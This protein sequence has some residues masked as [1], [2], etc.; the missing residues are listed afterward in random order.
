MKF[1]YKPLFEDKM[2]W[3]SII[4]HLLFGIFILIAPNVRHVTGSFVIS[5]LFGDSD[6][7]FY[8]LTSLTSIAGL[9]IQTK[10]KFFSIICLMPQ[11]LFL[12]IA[13]VGQ[14]TTI[15]AGVYPDGYP[16]VGGS[17]FLLIDQLPALIMCIAHGFV[18]LKKW[19]YT[20]SI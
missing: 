11:Q 5:R 8:F 16:P 1:S 14:I 9:V 12:N 4:Y 20:F 2:L 3:A 19:M 18:M 15:Y 7:I 13:L 10:W 17:Y 6:I